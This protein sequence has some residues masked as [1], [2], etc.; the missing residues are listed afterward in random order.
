VVKGRKRGGAVISEG[1]G[2]GE[3]VGEGVGGR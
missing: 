3:L 2:S 1:L